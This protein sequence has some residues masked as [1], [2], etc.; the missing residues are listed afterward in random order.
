MRRLVIVR[1]DLGVQAHFAVLVD[2]RHGVLRA[3]RVVNDLVLS[4]Q[5][6]VL[7]FRAD[8]ATVPTNVVGL[9]DRREQLERTLRREMSANRAVIRNTI[10]A[11]VRSKKT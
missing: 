1:L 10:P 5:R 7:A 3:E 9:L 11:L 8:A 2:R 4:E 6:V